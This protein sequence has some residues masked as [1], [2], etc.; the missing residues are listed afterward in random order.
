MLIAGTLGTA[1][2]DMT[3]FMTGLGLGGASLV[4][5]GIVATLIAA[6]SAGLLASTLAYW[7]V[8]VA[9]RA[10]GTSFGDF[11]AQQMGLSASAAV[12]ALVL[13]GILFFRAK[14]RPRL[15]APVAS[16]A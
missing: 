8:V 9:I 14:P 13:A 7:F 6:R 15:A 1:L 10:A 11:S 2:G 5:S 4:L 12:S 16:S 3:S